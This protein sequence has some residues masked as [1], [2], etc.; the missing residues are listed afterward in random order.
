MT[1]KSKHLDLMA[2]SLRQV[3]RNSG[4]L[5]KSGLGV[6]KLRDRN[7]FWLRVSLLPSFFFLAS[8][9]WWLPPWVL[10]VG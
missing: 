7:V 9:E 5:T 2:G 6:E 1:A 8:T 10:S 4:R 3:H